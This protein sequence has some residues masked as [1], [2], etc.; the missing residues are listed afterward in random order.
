MLK[1]PDFKK[2]F[3]RNVTHALSANVPAVIRMD[4]LDQLCNGIDRRNRLFVEKLLTH[5]LTHDKNPVVRHEAAFTLG[6]LYTRGDIAG[7]ES[8]HAL[9]EKTQKDPA[10]IVR[11]EAVETLGWY[12]FPEAMHTLKEC[13]CDSNTEIVATARI[14]LARFLSRRKSRHAVRRFKR[15]GRQKIRLLKI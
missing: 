4:C 6:Q 11:H 2:S 7:T 1:L 14:A 10:L 9:C 8:I 15:A 5:V 13:R 12:V 3:R